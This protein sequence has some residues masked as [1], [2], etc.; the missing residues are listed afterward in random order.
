MNLPDKV[1]PVEE[2]LAKIS[3]GD[4]LMVGSFLGVGC[5]VT[6]VDALTASEVGELELVNT[7]TDFPDRFL[8][9]LY[10]RRKVRKA[11]A[12]WIGWNAESVEQ[13]R[14]GFL[15]VEFV[16]IAIIAERARAAGAGMGGVLSPVGVGTFV[17]EGKEV[18]ERDGRT[19]LVEAPLHA[20]VCILRCAVADRWGNVV[21]RRTARHFHPTFATAATIVIAEAE[22]I[23]EV[24]EIDPEDVDT[25]GVFVD[26]V[27]QAVVP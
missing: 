25:S 5:P 13:Y 26:H 17:A 6:M 3:S 8:G 15:Q 20:D 10:H 22:R 19:Y 21:Y 1:V 4:R 9:R 23:V 27:V 14:E 11:I 7:S 16:P 24:G 2:A 12:S 18:L